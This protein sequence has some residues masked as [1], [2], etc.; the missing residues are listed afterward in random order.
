EFHVGGV[1]RNPLAMVLPAAPPLA[2]A[3]M[4]LFRDSTQG[5]LARLDEIRG[6]NLALLE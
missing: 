5:I 1:H 4:A 3:Q 2:A 6:T